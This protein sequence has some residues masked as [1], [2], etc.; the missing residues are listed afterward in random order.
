MSFARIV[1]IATAA[2]LTASVA[3]AQT[4][5]P[6]PKRGGSVIVGYESGDP[7]SFDCHATTGLN[8]LTFVA[9]HYS[10]LLRYDVNAYPKVEGDL[11]ESWNVSPDGLSYSF[12]LRPNVKFHDGSPLTSADVK[13][14]YERIRNPPAGV[15]SLRK[16]EFSDITAID[17][18]D[19]LTIVFRSA[20]PNAALLTSFAN[21]FNCIYSARRLA[22]SQA[23]PL[24]NVM[25]TGPFVPDQYVK[26]A[27][28]SGKRFDG[29]FMPGRPYLDSYKIA[30]VSPGTGPTALA[31]GQIE[32]LLRTL[33]P[34]EIDS[35]KSRM[36]DKANFST[37]PVLV[38]TMAVF[39]AAR[40]PFDDVRVRRALTLAMDRKDQLDAI[41]RLTNQDMTGSLVRP[42]SEMALTTAE[43]AQMP[44]FGDDLKASQAEAR[45][46]LAEA[47]QSNLKFKLLSRPTSPYN[48]LGIIA[49]DSWRQIGV[50]VENNPLDAGPY[51]TAMTRNDFDV[52]VDV[53]GPAAEDPS[54][55]LTK[56][57]P[58][59][60]NNYAGYTDPMLTDLFNRQNSAL[61]TAARKQLVNAFERQVLS[62]AYVAPMYWAG[63]TQGT[64]AY[65]HG[66]K[67]TPIFF[68][69]YDMASI[70]RD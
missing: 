13:A 2:A 41:R 66:W 49:I 38:L 12:K 30:L 25:G 42:G 15:V 70:W 53:N 40:K 22:E 16:T 7:A 6:A 67:A 31:G 27:S 47:G 37:G 35:I 58:G 17:T 3:S 59:A 48:Q 46:L 62:Q 4:P 50:T 65:V 60:G 5:S 39:N 26:G 18:P 57:V 63:W 10:L 28:W 19:P 45:R 11:A 51:Q 29:Y 44:G 64:A 54:T 34:A 23:Y 68:V 9:P 69:G 8:I 43:L 1:L 32:M 20:A 56:F 55:V 21:P 14:S 52:V 61:D 36:G 24:T 33:Q